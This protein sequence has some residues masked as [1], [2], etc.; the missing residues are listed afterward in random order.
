VKSHFECDQNVAN[1]YFDQLEFSQKN[2]ENFGADF[3]L[4]EGSVLETPKSSLI[5][6][7]SNPIN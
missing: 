2:P 7:S 1:S 5:W 6:T 3:V 4:L